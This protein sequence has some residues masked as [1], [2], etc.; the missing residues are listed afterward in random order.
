MIKKI[1]IL[2]LLVAVGAFAFLYFRGGKDM[3]QKTQVDIPTEISSIK[4]I[5]EWEFLTVEMEE[6]E[7]TVIPRKIISDDQFAR[8]YKGTAR[9]GV[10]MKDAAENWV[11]TSHDTVRITLPAIRI[12]DEDIIDDTQTRT[13]YENGKITPAIKNA[14][15]ERAKQDMRRRAM[16]KENITAA[17]E[18]AQAQFTYMF[19]SMGFKM[20]H[21]N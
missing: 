15:Y 17:R 18:N 16:S 11:V 4:E 5:A 9:L 20:V 1:V 13:F 8:I 21:F 6:F 12:L 14:L 7:D 19:R 3:R 2:L 10:D